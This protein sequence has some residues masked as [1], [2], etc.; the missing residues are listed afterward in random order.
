VGEFSTF[1]GPVLVLHEKKKTNTG[2]A[3]TVA[4]S[5]ILFP[6]FIC[7]KFFVLLVKPDGADYSIG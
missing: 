5:T 3:K 6:V 2:I 4:I 1:S 7:F